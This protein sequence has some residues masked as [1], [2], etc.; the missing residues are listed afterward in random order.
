MRA[1]SAISAGISNRPWAG[2]LA[3]GALPSRSS[4]VRDQ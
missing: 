2:A 1:G 4:V 3:Q